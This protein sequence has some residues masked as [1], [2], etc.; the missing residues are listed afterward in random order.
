MD[1]YEVSEV[2]GSPPP[3]RPSARV[4]NILT[5][6]ILV[7]FG[8]VLSYF[9][10]IFLN[11][12]SSLNPFPPPTLNPALFTPTFTVTPRFTLVPSWT[13]TNAPVTVTETP[14]PT[15]TPV[16]TETLV[17]S[18]TPIP[19]N[20][21]VENPISVQ[22]VMA[23]TSK[24]YT[25]VLQQGSPSAIAGAEFHQAGGCDWLGV[26]GQATS[27]NGEAVR[28]LFVQLGGSLPGLESVDK[29]VMTGLAPQYGLG[30]FEITLADKLVASNST[31]W[32]QLLDQQNLPL[33][34]RIYFNTYDD[35]QK[36]LVIIYFSQ[37]R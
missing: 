32:V 14:V 34:E 23:S 8:C 1:S 6:L 11:P 19:P 37:V 33:S 16:P 12:N 21:M 35:C 26:A 5:I 7:A 30:G 18:E 17:P 24:D 22:P 36:N 29:L 15:I 4:W 13:S 20:P 10:L 3:K 9:T 31:L 28:G 27:L 25:F 2:K